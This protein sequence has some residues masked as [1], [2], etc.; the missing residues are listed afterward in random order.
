MRSMRNPIR[1]TFNFG[2]CFCSS[3]SRR[4]INFAAVSLMFQPSVQTSEHVPYATCRM[5]QT[6]LIASSPSSWMISRTF[7]TFLS[8][9]LDGGRP[10]CSK[11]SAKLWQLL[12]PEYHSRVF[13]LLMMLTKTVFYSIS[14]ASE[15]LLSRLKQKSK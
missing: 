8:I 10:A 6:L 3:F 9:R 2:L 5:L 12:K 11:P 1:K 7:S 4:D 14:C 13:V 15:T